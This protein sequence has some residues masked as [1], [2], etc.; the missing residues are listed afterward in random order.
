MSAGCQQAK[1]VEASLTRGLTFDE[2]VSH[3]M[4]TTM[5]S[6]VTADARGRISVGFLPTGEIKSSCREKSKEM[7]APFADG[8]L[9][10]LFACDWLAWTFSMNR[11]RERA[12]GQVA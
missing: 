6:R 1:Y 4:G 5:R 3:L 9:S 8:S 11:W 12:L 7:P 10:F 2:S